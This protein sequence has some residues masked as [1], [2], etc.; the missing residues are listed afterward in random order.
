MADHN[1][2]GFNPGAT[3]GM[4]WSVTGRLANDGGSWLLE[5]R[6]FA[7]PDED[8]TSGNHYVFRYAGEGGYEGLAA[9]AL[10]LPTRQGPFIVNSPIRGVIFEGDPAPVPNRV[11]QPPA[12]R[13]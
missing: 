8:F 10:A 13:V 2:F 7:Q 6:G 3:G 4:V 9:I 5:G 11:S 12:F 1:Y